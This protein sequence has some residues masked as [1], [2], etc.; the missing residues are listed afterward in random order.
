MET[1]YQNFVGLID[2]TEGYVLILVTRGCHGGILYMEA[3]F[4]IVRLY[5]VV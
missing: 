5:V 3:W 4:V 1:T 2:Q